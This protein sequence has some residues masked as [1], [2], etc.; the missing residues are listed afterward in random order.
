MKKNKFRYIII[1]LFAI[2]LI[3]ELC[4][5]DYKSSFQWKQSLR[6]LTPILMIIAMVLSIRHTKRHGEN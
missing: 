1:I 5:Y 2:L 6:L 3:I 4:I